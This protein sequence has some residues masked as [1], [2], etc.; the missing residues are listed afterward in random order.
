MNEHEEPG[1]DHP[2]ERETD[3]DEGTEEPERPAMEEPGEGDENGGDEPPAPGDAGVTGE[4]PVEIPGAAGGE[5]SDLDDESIFE[6]EGDLEEIFSAMED[7]KK[8]EAKA[9]ADAMKSIESGEKQMEEALAN[10]SGELAEKIQKQLQ[11]RTKEDQKSF[12]SEDDFVAN[13]R[14]KNALEKT[15]YHCLHYLAFKAEDGTADKRVLYEALKDTLSK[16][17]VDPV[18]EHMFNFGL[19]ALVKVQ[20]YEKPA[21]SFKK[22]VF[23]LQVNKKKMQALLQQIGPP[24]SKRPVVTEKEKKKMINDFFSDDFLG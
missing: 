17:P 20:L 5:V 1:D 9:V 12:V 13:A 24:L 10:V 22:G 7:V 15:W 19:G 16:S 8:E 3:H 2:E 4:D 14:Q 11:E 21:V 18:P 6:S 23:T